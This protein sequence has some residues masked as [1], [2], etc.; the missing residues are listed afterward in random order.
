MS[1]VGPV[2]PGE[3]T[4]VR[5]ASFAPRSRRGPLER[6]FEQHRRAVLGALLTSAALAGSGYLYATRPRPEPPPPPPYPSQVTA[7]AYLNPQVTG[8]GTDPRSFSFDVG[9]T[10]EY[11]PPVTVT[12]IS[13]PYAGLSVTSSPRTPFRTRTGSP[14]KITI[15]V[16]VTECGKVP[17]N[18]GLPFLD[19]TLRNTHAIEDHSFILGSRYAQDLSRALQVACSNDFR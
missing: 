3:G 16:R 8:V 13:Q 17:R 9:M 1:G 2:E 18:A 19:V 6:C 11:G 7:I 14:R 12:R 5:D 10:M 15:T 4:H